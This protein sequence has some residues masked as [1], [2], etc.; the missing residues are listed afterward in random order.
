MK[1]GTTAGN[2]G[3]INSKTFGKGEFI[4]LPN[5][6]LGTNKDAYTIQYLGGFKNIPN[7]GELSAISHSA[8]FIAG[9]Q[10]DVTDPTKPIARIVLARIPYTELTAGTKAIEFGKGLDELYKNLSNKNPKAPEFKIFDALK[11]ISDKDELGSTF[12]KELRGNIYANVQRR[13][14]EIEILLQLH[15]II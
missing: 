9:I 5:S 6:T 1:I 14:F 11:I 3:T 8:S 2:V 7:N 15:I 4:V 12:D 10:N 13:M